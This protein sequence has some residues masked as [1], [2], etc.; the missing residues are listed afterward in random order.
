MNE[1][2][3]K[4]KSKAVEAW[5]ELVKVGGPVVTA[6]VGFD[7]EPTLSPP[8]PSP[9]QKQKKKEK[10]KREKHMNDPGP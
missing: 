6:P 5:G 8:S 3:L 1:L 9:D 2:N 4:S 7:T 10:K